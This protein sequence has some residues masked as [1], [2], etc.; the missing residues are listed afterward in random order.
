MR[1]EGQVWESMESRQEE[2]WLQLAPKRRREILDEAR[3]ERVSSQ[4]V[5]SNQEDKREMRAV[6]K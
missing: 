5:S 2:A 4:A 6:T 3:I 1:I